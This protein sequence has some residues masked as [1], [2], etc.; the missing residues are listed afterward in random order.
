MKRREF[1]TLLGVAAAAWPIAAWAQQSMPTIGYIDDEPERTRSAFFRAFQQG[2]AAAGFTEGRNV[3]IE[4]RWTDGRLEPIPEMVA[5]L[6]RRQVT[7]IASMVGIP[8][9][10]AA[11][12]ATTTI[13]IVFLGGFDPVKIGLVASL[14]R[15]GG[16][17]T[18]VTSLGLELGPKRLEVM[19]ELIPAAKVIAL[20]INPDHPNAE[21]QS[22]EMQA[23]AGA[24]G[25]QVRIVYARAANEFD[26][27][28]ASLA[29][30]SAEGLV[31]GSGEPFVVSNGQLGALAAR[32]AVPTISPNR[33]FAAAGGLA[34]YGGTGEEAPRLAGLYVGRILK[35]EKPSDLPVQQVT[36]VQLIINLKTAKALGLAVPITLLGRADEVIE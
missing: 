36:K 32:H 14:N 33:E 18:G 24:L 27:A 17:V 22:R 4:Y 12:A 29:Q 2:L 21:S 35:G 23:A 7:V 26:A 31:I 34:S 16:N 6:V 13:P 3:A 11:K 15:P 1:I 25:L 20:L 10:T 9:A 8:G 30:L 28:F 5:D 19:H